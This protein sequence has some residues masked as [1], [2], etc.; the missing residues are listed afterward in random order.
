MSIIFYYSHPSIYSG[1]VYVLFPIYQNALN[2]TIKM[3]E[4]WAL[5]GFAEI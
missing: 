4:H 2:R 3:R 1:R 5:D